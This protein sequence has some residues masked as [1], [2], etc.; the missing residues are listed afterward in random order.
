MKQHN[1]KPFIRFLIPLKPGEAQ[2]P[3]A[4]E[5]YKMESDAEF[6]ERIKKA[7]GKS[8]FEE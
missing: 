5:G 7:T 4:P 6:R 3:E 2:P 1:D 8:E